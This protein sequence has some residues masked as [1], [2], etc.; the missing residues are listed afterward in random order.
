MLYILMFWIPLAAIDP[1]VGVIVA[2]SIGA[3]GAYLAA[4]H[5][6]S[7]KIATTE[8][9]QL[10]DESRAIREWSAARIDKCDEQIANLTE[11]LRMAR[12][13]ITELERENRRLEKLLRDREE[14]LDY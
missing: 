12:A 2:A 6:M 5:R 8:A 14:H 13:R 7:G 4:A 10:W 9:A 1:V 11:Q 3:V